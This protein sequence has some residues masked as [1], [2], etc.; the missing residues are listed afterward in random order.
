MFAPGHRL[1]GIWDAHETGL[2]IYGLVSEYQYAGSEAA[3]SAARGLADWMIR[4]WQADPDVVPVPYVMTTLEVENGMLALFEQTGDER[5]RSFAAE[6]MGLTEWDRPIVTGRWTGIKGH[7]CDYLCRCVAQRMLAAHTP[8]PQLMTPAQRAL[9]FMLHG[10]GMMITGHV[11]EYECW[12]DTQEGLAALGE[13]C[14]TAYLIRLLDR[15]M[16]ET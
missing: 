15:L 3:L 9:D 12:H 5:Y 13:T 16:I 2:L 11:S 4:Q 6:F 14:A 7:A 8:A 1:S 10:N